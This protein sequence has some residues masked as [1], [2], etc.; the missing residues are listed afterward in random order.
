VKT[1]KKEEPEIL[2]IKKK[3]EPESAKNSM[4]DSL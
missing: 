2:K 4:S 1:K 3:E